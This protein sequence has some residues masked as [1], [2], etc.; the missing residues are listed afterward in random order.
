MPTETEIAYP[1]DAALRNARSSAVWQITLGITTGVC[2]VLWR[3]LVAGLTLLGESV[4]ER[5]MSAL[6][7]IDAVILGVLTFFTARGSRSAAIALLGWWLLGVI[8]TWV[9][10]G[11]VLPPALLMTVLVGAGLLCGVNGTVAK[12]ALDRDPRLQP[13]PPPLRPHGGG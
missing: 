4:A 1:T 7:A 13:V 12:Y 9:R 5:P 6:F 11:T 8:G 10:L 3:L 2:V